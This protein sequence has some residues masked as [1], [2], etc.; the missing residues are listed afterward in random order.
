MKALQCPF[1]SRLPVSSVVKHA[2]ALLAIADQCPIMKHAVQYSNMASSK[3]D[4]EVAGR[5][6]YQT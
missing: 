4:T 6:I 5:Y 2:P 3:S 1:L